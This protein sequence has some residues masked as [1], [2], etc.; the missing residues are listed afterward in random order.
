[1]WLALLMALSLDV[2]DSPALVHFDLSD[3]GAIVVPVM[4]EGQGPFRFLLDTGASQSVVAERL[5]LRLGLKSEAMTLML[6]P[7]GERVIQ[8]VSRVAT[9]Q[10]GPV[11]A[12]D[13]LMTRLVGDLLKAARD[14]DGI[15]GQDVL[16]RST[17]TIDYRRRAVV[18]HADGAIPDGTRLRLD[19]I[20]GRAIVSL[21]R[22][23]SARGVLRMI[24]DTGADGIVLFAGPG[25]A[26]PSVTPLDIGLLRTVSGV[27]LVRRVLLERFSAGQ[28]ELGDVIA[29]V[30][31][32]RDTRG[33]D[34]DGLLPLHMFSAVTFDVAHGVLVLQR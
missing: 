8:H 22:G 31:E 25:R 7:G 12:V 6:T 10:V 18:W 21:P 34:G 24:P 3:E 28:I 5:A 33:I 16:A 30:V 29:S 2:L 32:R 11:H 13:L 9:L 15:V 23:T 4:V 27:Q 1:M 20:D 26:L 14:V 19:L 17:Y